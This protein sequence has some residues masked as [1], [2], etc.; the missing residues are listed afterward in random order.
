MK[1]VDLEWSWYLVNLFI[2]FSLPF[3]NSFLLLLD[4]ANIRKIKHMA[5]G[6]PIWAALSAVLGQADA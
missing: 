3:V 1:R 4:V 6:G 2:Y 5:Q